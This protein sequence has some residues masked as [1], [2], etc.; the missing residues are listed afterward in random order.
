[1]LFRHKNDDP[2][3]NVP[4]DVPGLAEAMAG[5][6]WEPAP[7]QPFDGHLE[8]DINEITRAM[9]GF[10]R[11]LSAVR[12]VTLRV[13][14]TTFRDSFRGSIDGRTVT[15]ASA[16][17]ALEGENRYSTGEVKSVAVC[18]VEL[19]SMLPIVWIQPRQFA[20]VI[21]AKATPTG[22]PAFDE[23]YIVVAIPGAEASVLTPDLQQLIMAHDD[24]AFRAER[25]LFGCVSKGRFANVEA[26]HS[27]ISEVLNI[28]AAVPSSVIPDHVDHSEDDLIARISRLTTLEEG[29][30]FLQGLT[31]SERERVAHSDSP[32]SALA[33]VRT[34]EEAMARFKT[35]DRDQQMQLMAQFMPRP[36]LREG[37]KAGACS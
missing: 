3:R 5:Q 29:L 33:D 21:R 14:D 8:G 18:A 22:N 26:V 23:R 13:G 2:F 35:L 19:P 25:Y 10:S 15:V 17:T 16:W 37:M 31:P 32:L 20:P 11:E 36:G 6:G 28:V 4:P 30:A 9:Y 7:D 1:M 27:R 24:W 12:E 34:P